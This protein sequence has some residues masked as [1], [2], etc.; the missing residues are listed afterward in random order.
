MLNYKR[1][2]DTSKITIEI[3]QLFANIYA[4]GLTYRLFF[5]NRLFENTRKNVLKDKK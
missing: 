2:L 3:G 4:S 1:Y 5:A